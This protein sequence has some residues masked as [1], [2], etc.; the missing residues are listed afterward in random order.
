MWPAEAHGHPEA[1]R[2]SDYDVGAEFSRRL[3]Q[4][5]AEEVG[6]N[7]HERAFFVCG[8]RQGGVVGQFAVTRRVLK[9]H[10][11]EIAV[12]LQFLSRVGNN[13]VDAQVPSAGLHDIDGL[14]QHRVVDQ[15]SL[16][17]RFAIAPVQHGHGLGGR[18]GLVE[19]GG[20]GDF[21]SGQVAD[22]LLKV[23][24][25]FEPPLGDFRLVRRIRGVPAGVFQHVALD[26]RRQDGLVVAHAD[27]VVH[28]PVHRR[29]LP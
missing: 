18:R 16:A 4:R 6:C 15:E 28:D 1:L 5:Q 3:Q 21:H 2:V 24:Q 7:G 25:G 13:H 14:G 12:A 10:A 9:Q 20:V 22:H 29:H 27:H 8:L 19:Q 23:Q 26:H 11:E 17:F